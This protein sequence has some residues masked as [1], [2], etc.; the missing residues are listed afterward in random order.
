MKLL[1]ICSRG[2]VINYTNYI[3]IWLVSLVTIL[4]AKS[5]EQQTFPRHLF[6]CFLYSSSAPTHIRTINPMWWQEL[7][8]WVQ[9]PCAIQGYFLVILAFS[10]DVITTWC[11]CLNVNSLVSVILIFFSETEIK[12]TK[13]AL[14]PI[15]H[16][17][18]HVTLCVCQCTFETGSPLNDLQKC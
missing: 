14:H 16:W 8:S 2:T 5:S 11:P 7:F 18:I 13:A 12:Q 17:Y 3:I 1:F 9:Y 15:N 10:Q 6:H 4:L